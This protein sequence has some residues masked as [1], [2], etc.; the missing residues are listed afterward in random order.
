MTFQP[1]IRKIEKKDNMRVIG[2]FCDFFQDL[3]MSMDGISRDDFLKRQQARIDTAS[4]NGF[5]Y[6]ALN[7]NSPQG[8]LLYQ[9]E[10]GAL[11]IDQLYVNPIF[12]GNGFGKE[13]IRQVARQS[14]MDC[15]WVTLQLPTRQNKDY[16]NAKGFYSSL[17]FEFRSSDSYFLDSM[18]LKPEQASRLFVK[19]EAGKICPSLDFSFSSPCRIAVNNMCSLCRDSR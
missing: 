5:G 15:Q 13:L 3:L 9:R 4:R 8:Y 12:R 1:K 11:F 6:V 19:K 7:S 14:L 10:P 17:G 16:E 18:V 2:M